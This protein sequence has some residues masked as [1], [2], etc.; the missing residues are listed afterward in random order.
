MSLSNSLPDHMD[1]VLR[2]SRVLDALWD[3]FWIKVGEFGKPKVIPWKQYWARV[4]IPLT[5]WWEEA[6]LIT[7]AFRPG[8]GTGDFSTYREWT[9]A[10]P[11]EFQFLEN[12]SRVYPRGK[13]SADGSK[14]P[15]E[16]IIPLFVT[17]TWN[18]LAIP[19][20][21]TLL[22]LWV[23]WENALW[24]LWKMQTLWKPS[25]LL[26]VG[27]EW[28]DRFGDPHAIYSPRESWDVDNYQVAWFL[29]TSDTRSK[30][31]ELLQSNW[32]KPLP[33]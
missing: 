6:S 5:F 8:D 27:G 31:F 13:L 11:P 32:R 14:L 17:N 23:V 10:I 3:N 21:S 18:N 30:I 20:N 22:E 33:Y 19:H 16:W 9:L 7:I 24:I 4:D 1:T 29:S 2:N 15:I 26:T 28:A 25:I 12:P